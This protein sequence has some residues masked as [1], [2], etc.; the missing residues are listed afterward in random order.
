MSVK[1]NLKTIYKDL[2]DDCTIEDVVFYLELAEKLERSE[3]DI[4][5][6]RVFTQEQVKKRLAT[7]RKKKYVGLKKPSRISKKS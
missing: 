6:G 3:A 7:W 2:P 4:K 5:A 1:E